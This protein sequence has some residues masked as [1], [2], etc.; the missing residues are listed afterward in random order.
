MEK[1]AWLRINLISEFEFVSF[2][3]YHQN[4]SDMKKFLFLIFFLPFTIYG[5]DFTAMCGKINNE[6]WSVSTQS[7]SLFA[8]HDA[9]VL[10]DYGAFEIRRGKLI[11]KT[12]YRVKLLNES[13]FEKWGTK[14][15]TFFDRD[16]VTI[17]AQTVWKDEGEIIYTPLNPND[18][19]KTKAED[20]AG[21]KFTFPKLSVGAIVE[22]TLERRTSRYSESVP[23]SWNFQTSVPVKWSEFIWTFPAGMT[24]SILQRGEWTHPMYINQALDRETKQRMVKV[25]VPAFP[26]EAFARPPAALAD[27]AEV[28]VRPAMNGIIF[29]WSFI[30]EILYNQTSFGKELNKDYPQLKAAV[31]QITERD[32][33]AEMKL[34]RLFTYVREKFPPNLDKSR[35][36]RRGGTL[37]AFNDG[38]VSA[39]E[40][41]LIMVHLLRGAGFESS[42]VMTKFRSAGAINKE[43]PNMSDIDEVLV[44][45]KTPQ[46]KEYILD[47]SNKSVGFPG[48]EE[49][50]V[51]PVA[52]LL[53]STGRWVNVEPARSIHRSMTNF[54]IESN[55][56]VKAEF[57]L[58]QEGFLALESKEQIKE[59][60]NDYKTFLVNNYFKFEKPEF[61][62]ISFQGQDSLEASL[63]GSAKFTLPSYAQV[64]DDKIYI[65]PTVV[66][67]WEENPFKAEKRVGAIDF[68]FP[69]EY[70]YVTNM[71]IP[72]GYVVEDMPKPQHQR[73]AGGEFRRFLSVEGDTVQTVIR[74]KIDKIIF[75]K[76]KYPIIKAVFDAFI[77]AQSD[78][79]VL[80]KG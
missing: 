42:F 27:V 41:K 49:D 71:K 56:T 54:S 60:L 25:N 45:V 50:Q 14:E 63:K 66:D 37:K 40:Q 38:N 80:K 10:C 76:D 39:T 44:Y 46:M 48:L 9:V 20:E 74:L 47:P 3:H 13:A 36:I 30:N 21:Y 32:T 23:V 11:G 77:T 70:S 12:H 64:I 43:V 17:H 28:H 16:E 8:G 52:W 58:L 53:N 62:D 68:V 73:F 55:G 35:E 34:R 59:S 5:Q 18:I 26:K 15:M 33:T 51:S 24:S 19:F 69:R 22:F 78:Q 2:N 75:E 65:N 6:D 1:N 67:R 31:E 79:I 7:D 61:E 4:F 72:A 29:N 57:E